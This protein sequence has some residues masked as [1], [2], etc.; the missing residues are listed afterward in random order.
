MREPLNAPAKESL[1]PPPQGYPYDP[2][3][4][5]MDPEETVDLPR[6][7]DADPRHYELPPPQPKRVPYAHAADETMMLGKRQRA[8]VMEEIQ[9]EL[10]AMALPQPPDPFDVG[11]PDSMDWQRSH[12]DPMGS[13]EIPPAAEDELHELEPL[14]MV[15][16]E[17]FR[18]PLQRAYTGKA[19]KRLYALLAVCGVCLVGWIWWQLPANVELHIESTPNALVQTTKGKQLGT[20]PLKLK[21]K[22]GQRLQ[23]RLLLSGY[24]AREV[25]ILLSSKSRQTRR[26][27][28]QKASVRPGAQ[29]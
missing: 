11:E 9:Q 29:R 26:Y 14:V 2:S 23:L 16:E 20:T 3:A 12:Y 13:V 25:S 18:S 15:D 7:P 19:K 6:D 5:A 28:L 4:Q 1:L 27:T 8:E 24:E 10:D 21:G 22:E 17:L